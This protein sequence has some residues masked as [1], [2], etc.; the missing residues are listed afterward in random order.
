MAIILADALGRL[1]IIAS[2]SFEIRV[3]PSSRIKPHRA[4]RVARDDFRV[5]AQKY[6]RKESVGLLRYRDLNSEIPISIS[7]FAHIEIGHRSN[8]HHRRALPSLVNYRREVTQLG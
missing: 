8:T 7:S 1:G 3:R 5:F 2:S 4:E 6:V